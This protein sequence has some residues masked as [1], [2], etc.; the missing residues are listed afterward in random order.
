MKAD[1]DGLVFY[2]VGKDGQDDG[3]QENENTSEPDVVVT[4]KGRSE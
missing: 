2:S 4:L 1:G 3:G